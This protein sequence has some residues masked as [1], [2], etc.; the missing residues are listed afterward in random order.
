MEINEKKLDRQLQG[1]SRYFNSGKLGLSY[2]DRCGCLNY[3]TGVGKSYTAI[4]VIKRYFKT[5]S[6]TNIVLLV[7][8]PLLTQWEKVV[9]THF[10]KYQ[11]KY[12]QMYSPDHIL[13]NNIILNPDVLIVDEL[14]AFYS[15]KRFKLLDKTFI[16]YKDILGLTATYEDINGRHIPVQQ[17]CPIIDK[18]GEEEAIREGYISEYIEYNLGLEFNEEEQELHKK[19]SEDIRKGLSKFGNKLDLAYNCLSGGK[20]SN[21][22]KYT[23][24]QFCQGWAQHNGWSTNAPQD[25]QDLWNPTAIFHYAVHLSRAIKKR[26]DLI[27]T[28]VSKLSATIEIMQRFANTKSVIFSQSTDFANNLYGII[29]SLI[30]DNAV[31]YHS[32]VETQYFPSPKTGLP[33]KHGKVRLKKRAIHRIQNNLSNHLI[34]A[35]SLDKGLD[36]PELKLSVTTSGT[37]NPTQYKQRKG[38]PIRVDTKNKNSVSII[39]NLYMKRS[40]EVDWLKKRQSLSTNIIY[41][42]DSIDEISYKPIIRKND[43]INMNNI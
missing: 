16:R 11:S 40:K 38:R 19:L 41:Q 37:Q 4:L 32:K 18:I 22:T 42:I 17:F 24:T 43:E 7:P 6:N 29:N 21:G 12:I 23:S 10:T 13:N 2:K 28:S 14:D 20:H 30:P 9:N 15:E 36:I 31:I 1:V 39:V 26:K 8:S 34:T 3:M 25:V 27:Y 5:N 35:S 33:L